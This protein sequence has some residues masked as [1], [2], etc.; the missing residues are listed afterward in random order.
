MK[1][2]P[3]ILT[4]LLSIV[5]AAAALVL[6][7]MSFYGSVLAVL[8]CIVSCAAVSDL[9]SLRI[10]DRLI[11]AGL[12]LFLV[13]S[14]AG[15]VF[16][17]AGSAASGNDPRH[18]FFHRFFGA[19]LPAV[20]SGVLCTVPLLFLS[21]FADRVFH[22]TTLGGGDLKLIF[23]LCLYFPLET[24]LYGL[25]CSCGYG[26]ITGALL[27]SGRRRGSALHGFPLGPAIVLGWWTAR[28]LSYL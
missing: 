1:K 2:H 9:I 6:H 17:G 8:A 28:M 24:D 15:A 13:W 7:G 11:L 27:L 19:F 10:P 5:L 12:L 4:A 3:G 25:L 16:P 18:G 26:I 23:L 14:L 20:L 21:L 22:K